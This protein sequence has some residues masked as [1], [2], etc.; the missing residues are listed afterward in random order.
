MVIARL[1]NVSII[2]CTRNRAYVIDKC[3]ASIAVALH[4]AQALEAELLIVDNNSTDD[5][6]ARVRLWGAGQSFPV[7]LLFESRKGLS[8]ARNCGLR[9]ARGD[10]IAFT[11]DDCRLSETYFVDLVRH[12]KGDEEP[13][14][15]G[16]R[17]DPGDHGDLALS[18]KTQ[19][20][21]KC[22]KI[23]DSHARHEN[24]GDSLV[25]C[26]M[27]LHRVLVQK[28]G[29]FDERLGAGSSIPGGEDT[30]YILRAYKAGFTVSYVGNMAV[31]HFHGRKTPTEGAKLLQ[32]YAYGW[33]ALYSKYLFS[34]PAYCKPFYWDVK[35]ALKEIAL[36]RNTFLPGIGFSHR[37]KVR[38][39]IIGFVK[40]GLL[41]FI[42]ALTLRS[43][44]PKNVFQA[45]EHA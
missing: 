10:V 28:L 11:D 20:E 44:A 7:R 38:Y 24:L 1:M 23:N 2:V 40:F 12:F 16:G 4:A 41:C 32:N 35:N 34:F 9:A 26:N 39:S 22:W 21:G 19:T 43:G 45:E 37:D 25:G 31:A 8:A 13:V 14:L 15:R 18:I 5:T 6:A 29:L 27:A 17:V 36:G 3:L 30:D 42:G 33:G